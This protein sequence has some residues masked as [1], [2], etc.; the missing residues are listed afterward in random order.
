LGSN[1]FLSQGDVLDGWGNRLEYAVSAKLT[2]MAGPAPASSETH[3]FGVI[4]AVDEF[5]RPTASIGTI[6]INND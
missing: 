2:P 4:A 1:T 5:G 3:K 6:D